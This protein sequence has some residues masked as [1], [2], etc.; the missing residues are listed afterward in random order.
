MPFKPVREQGVFWINIDLLFL[1]HFLVGSQQGNDQHSCLVVVPAEES[2]DIRDVNVPP[3][4]YIYIIIY[5]CCMR[6]CQSH[7][8]N[9]G[10]EFVI[11]IFYIL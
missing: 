10:C 1:I 9:Y 8:I 11:L 2:E 5:T 6:A 7:T 4:L 3:Y